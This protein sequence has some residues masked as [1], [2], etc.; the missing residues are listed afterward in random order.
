MIKNKLAE[1]VRDLKNAVVISLIVGGLFWLVGQLFEYVE[2]PF[3]GFYA[4]MGSFSYSVMSLF[5]KYGGGSMVRSIS[6]M[7][8]K[9]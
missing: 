4:M 7:W 5:F 2:D 3:F 9:T 8:R 1:V 6:K